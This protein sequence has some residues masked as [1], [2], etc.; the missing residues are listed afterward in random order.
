M[1][2]LVLTPLLCLPTVVAQQPVDRLLRALPEEAFVVFA[3]A[4]WDEIRSRAEHNTWAAFFRDEQWK[5]VFDVA[6]GEWDADL[7]E[8]ELGFDFDDLIA[9][10]HGAVAVSLDE[11]PRGFEGVLLVDAGEPRAAF[12][13]IFDA[14]WKRT[15][16]DS[17]ATSV[18]TF[19][20][21]SFLLDEDDA[22]DATNAALLEID[23]TFAL[24]MHDDLDALVERTHQVIDRLRG[25]DEGLGFTGTRAWAAADGGARRPALSLVMNM[26]RT[27]SFALEDAD[28]DQRDAV[29]E[30]G[31]LD[32]EWAYASADLGKGE[33]LDFTFGL[34]VPRDT[35][36]G[37]F[38]DFLG[39]VPTGMITRFPGD[40]T[41]VSLGRYDVWG[42][43]QHLQE[44][45]AQFAPEQHDEL[46]ST[47]AGFRAAMGLDVEQDLLA[48]LTGAFASFTMPVP[49]E[50]IADQLAMLG[51]DVEGVPAQSEGWIVGLDQAPRVQG[52]VDKLLAVFGIAEQVETEEFQGRP[53]YALETPFAHM[54]WAFTD[55]AFVYAPTPTPLRAVLRRADAEEPADG[56]RERLSGALAE[57]G[58]GA[59]WV[60]LTDTS[61]ML[62]GVMWSFEAAGGLFLAGVM[63]GLSEDGEEDEALGELLELDW[64]SAE[65]AREYFK[66]SIASWVTR[67]G[68]R[69][70]LRLRSR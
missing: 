60:T 19:E 63:E 32:L 50:E 15:E 69:L 55:D 64:P 7:E 1:S 12:E 31:I 62:H 45:L 3:T 18:R 70:Q 36:I 17:D 35:V 42:A 33:A 56:F 8:E 30:L 9:S 14:L 58:P 40:A 11:S 44:V 67:T 4:P 13:E 25:T 61:A 5:A 52:V 59:A 20:G 51:A 38:A 66:G 39:P 49:K 47:L 10:I 53:Y 57:A 65:L 34:H 29:E 23:G 24:V 2:H 54:L 6:T 21:V 43:W 68:D 48:R 41:N 27:L 46:Q 37:D 26:Q 22:E 28:E 16:E